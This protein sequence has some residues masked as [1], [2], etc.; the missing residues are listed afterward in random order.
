VPKV[1]VRTI[2]IVALLAMIPPMLIARARV[3][4][5]PQPRIHLVQD[6]DNQPKYRAQHASGVFADMRAMR[7]PVPGTVARD[8]DFMGRRISDLRDDDHFYRGL[9]DGDWATRLP[10]GVPLSAATLDRGRERFNIYCSPCHGESGDGN[11]MIHVRASQLMVINQAPTWVPPTPVFDQTVRERPVGHLFNT[12]TNGIR[13]MPA[14]GPQIP[15]ADRWAIVAW[16]RVLQRSQFASWDDVPA[17]ERMRLEQSRQT[18][19]SGAADE[20]NPS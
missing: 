8:A 7:P 4:R 16:L 20:G 17:G 6:M 15:E 12:I 19:A 10:E 2:V 9:V 14:Y 11:G 3:S 5:S 1:I 13:T 18:G